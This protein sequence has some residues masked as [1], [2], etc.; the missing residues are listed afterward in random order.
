[1]ESWYL[2]VTRFTENFLTWR[3]RRNLRK[4]ERQKKRHV[5]IEWIDA[6]LW[7][8]FVVLLINQYL[9]QA[10]QIPTPSM[11]NTLKVSDRLFVNKLVYGPELLPGI[12]K[13]R[14]LKTPSRHKIIIFESPTYISKGTAFDIAQRVLYMLTLSLWDIDK[15]ENGDPRAH[16]LIKR[17]MGVEGDRV[18]IGKGN[19]ELM[20]PGVDGWQAEDDFGIYNQVDYTTRRMIKP[21]D[22]EEMKAAVRLRE[23]E[24]LGLTPVP[25]DVEMVNSASSIMHDSFERSK[26]NNQVRHELQP[27]ESRYRSEY[28]RY[29]LGWYI[30]KGWIFPLGDNRDNSKDGRYFGPIRLSK[31]LG[32]ASFIYWP[33]PRMG[34]AK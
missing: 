26:I 24:D 1:M 17:A 30:P 5:I 10:Y 32:N 31:V 21:S 9:F 19:V 8:A 16:F 7:A 27:H 4:K 3:K 18:R 28:T 11:E 20:P 22:Y 6:F 2:Q 33:I 34:A 14:G 29:S 15:D 13:L 23:Y 25:S 12:G